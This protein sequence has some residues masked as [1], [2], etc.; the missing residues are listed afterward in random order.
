MKTQIKTII[1]FF[2]AGSSISVIPVTAWDTG[3]IRDSKIPAADSD[4]PASKTLS[5]TDPPQEKNKNNTTLNDS[6]AIGS[7]LTPQQVQ[8]LLVLHNTYR[9]DVGVGPVVWSEKIAIYA[10]QWADHLA[11]THCSM[12]HRPRSGTWTQEYGEN[13]FMGTAGYYDVSDAVTAWDSEKKDHHGDIITAANY[14]ATGHY[15]QIV[16]RN[17][18]QIGC[19]SAVCNDNIII[20]CN[21]DPQGNFL[22]QKPF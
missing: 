22:G 18:R 19:A 17:T 20:V 15:T 6:F 8:Q 4:Y 9:A 10:Q 3:G 11:S 12:E 21:Y 2:L 7:R 14:S 5:E 13:L 1:L 16:W